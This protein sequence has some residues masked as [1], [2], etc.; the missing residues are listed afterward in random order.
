MSELAD[1]SGR[2]ARHT[3]GQVRMELALGV[4]GAD[5]V[6]VGAQRDDPHQRLE[7]ADPEVRERGLHRRG[8][9]QPRGEQQVGAQHLQH[10]REQAPR[11]VEEGGAQRPRRGVGGEQ[12]P[13]R[14]PQQR[15]DLAYGGV[16]VRPGHGAREHREGRPQAVGDL[17]QHMA[18]RDGRAFAAGHR[19]IKA[20]EQRGG[21]GGGAG[22]AERCI[23]AR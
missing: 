22:L 1:A 8:V 19:C 3:L 12:A 4:V 7:R 15:A 18:L 21:V 13:Q 23:E 10:H 5:A 11:R 20:L 16:P 14:L 2:S 9:P 6:V 17:R